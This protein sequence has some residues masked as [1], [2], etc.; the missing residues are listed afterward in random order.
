[1]TVD[2]NAATSEAAA[3]A[4]ENLDARQTVTNDNPNP[5]YGTPSVTADPPINEPGETAPPQLSKRE[6]I[7][8][9]ARARRAEMNDDGGDQPFDDLVTN[10]AGEYIPP[11]LRRQQEEERA[12]REEEEAARAQHPQS[13]PRSFVLKVRGNDIPVI[14]RGELV[15]LAEIEPE[16]ADDFTDAQLIKLAQKQ[17]AA[18][19]VLDEAK[20]A[21]KT[22]RAAAHDPGDTQPASQEQQE[23][24]L[25]DETQP[26]PPHQEDRRRQLI[27]KIQFG[28]PEE[29]TQAFTEA[30]SDGVR[31]VVA[32]REFSQRHTNVV[33]IIKKAGDDFE[34]AN[35]D[36]VTDPDF[37]DLVYNRAFVA[38]L[39]KDLVGQ[40]L[41]PENVDAV[42]GNDVRTAMKAYATIAADGRVK[43]RAPNQ[44]LAA[45]AQAVR[46]KFNRP[47]PS[48]RPGVSTAARPTTAP[49]AHRQD[50]KRQLTPQPARTSAP[51]QSAPV[52]G[53]APVARSNA[54]MQMR[55]AR[56]QA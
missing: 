18:S 41:K 53:Q 26:E 10:E 51:I 55:K 38:E 31:E 36:L 25:D 24:D 1:M 45:A 46:A 15:K 42:V 27:E 28:D 11:F 21:K 12:R 52:S 40:G 44:M 3:L 33:A 7:V 48:T 22:A 43:T 54:V 4:A 23:T 2:A 29:A 35:A 39:K 32:E 13:E 5:D 9:N 17:V 47:A 8:A 16:E 6:Q 50:A 37:A 20:A 14:S 19:Q 56:G 49:M 30:V 34:A